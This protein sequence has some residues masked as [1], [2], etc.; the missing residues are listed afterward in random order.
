[1][2]KLIYIIWTNNKCKGNFYPQ[3]ISPPK[4][5]SLAASFLKNSFWEK[6]RAQS[7]ELSVSVEKKE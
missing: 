5:R 2:F 6:F 7:A 1:M 4:R 3:K